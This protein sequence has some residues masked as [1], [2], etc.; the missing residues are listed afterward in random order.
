MSRLQLSVKRNIIFDLS[1]E[2]LLK[3]VSRN[4]KEVNGYNSIHEILK[5]LERTWETK[6]LHV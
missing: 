5:L 6:F 1:R 2:W 4:K 3:L